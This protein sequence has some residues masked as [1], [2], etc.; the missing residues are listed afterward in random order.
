E[1][2]FRNKTFRVYEKIRRSPPVYKLKDLD[3]EAIW[4][5]FYSYKLQKVKMCTDKMLQVEKIVKRRTVRRIKQ[6]FNIMSGYYE[7]I[8]S[9][10]N[11]VESRLRKMSVVEN[12][13]FFAAD[14]D[15]YQLRFH[16][17]VAYVFGSE[18]GE[19]ITCIRHESF[20][21]PM[22]RK[23]GFYHFY[24]YSEVIKHQLVGDAYAPP[25]RTLEVEGKFGD[26]ITRAFNPPD[27]LPVARKH[28]E[29]IQIEMKSD[30]NVPI[31]F[32]YGK[33]IVKLHF[34]PAK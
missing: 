34:R 26:I 16:A 17:P 18:P 21:Y 11:E 9:L 23:A 31:K 28:I 25:M 6:V 13:L 22:D 5:T 3:G 19:W 14:D 8:T 2:G 12:R 33:T 30:Q 32:T 27:Y 1:Q 24:C 7:T 15:Q 29:S 10:K 4:G 20:P